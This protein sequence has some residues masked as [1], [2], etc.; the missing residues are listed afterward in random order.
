MRARQGVKGTLYSTI[1]FQ[2]FKTKQRFCYLDATVSKNA[3]VLS[4]LL[5]CPALEIDKL[6]SEYGHVKRTLSLQIMEKMI[7]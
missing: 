6:S 1:L 3:S 4:S 2:K 7:N 5:K